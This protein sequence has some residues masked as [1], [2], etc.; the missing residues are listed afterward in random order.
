MFR[1][2]L[3]RLF[4]TDGSW[5]S[6]LSFA[7][8][9]SWRFR[10]GVGATSPERC[11]RKG[12]H[13][14]ASNAFAGMAGDRV[15]LSPGHDRSSGPVQGSGGFAFHGPSSATARPWWTVVDR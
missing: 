6:R 4:G 8:S 14:R 3:S 15:R 10:T 2:T 11:R 9:V 13:A 12:I 1:E 5:G 7:G